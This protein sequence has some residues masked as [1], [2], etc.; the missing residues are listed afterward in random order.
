MP[1]PSEDEL[2]G[3]HLKR[4]THTE[5]LSYKESDS[6]HCSD[7]MLHIRVCTIYHVVVVYSS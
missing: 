3:Q 6:L 2:H 7:V 4:S 5:N 1:S